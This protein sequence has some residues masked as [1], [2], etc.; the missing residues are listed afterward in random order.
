M[1]FG[2]QR[3]ARVGHSV[4]NMPLGLVDTGE[5]RN[6]L[7]H[8]KW[9]CASNICEPYFH[10]FCQKW[11]RKEHFLHC[12]DE[13]DGLG[14][15]WMRLTHGN[16]IFDVLE[17]PAFKNI[18]YVGSFKHLSVQLFYMYFATRPRAS[19][20]AVVWSIGFQWCITFFPFFGPFS[21]KHPCSWGLR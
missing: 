21:Q 3:W 11:W 20:P 14:T 5:K 17:P 13:L 2:C 19:L 8:Q 18:A 1:F 9:A 4:P 10:E 16:F 12:G 6:L 15:S 7:A